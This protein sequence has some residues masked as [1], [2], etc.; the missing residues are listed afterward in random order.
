MTYGNDNTAHRTIKS[1]VLAH[2]HRA[3]GNVDYDALTAEVRQAF[4]DSAWKKTHWAWYKHQILNGRF[5]AMFTDAER[6]ALRDGSP[7]ATKAVTA[8]LLPP[9]SVSKTRGPAAKDPEIKKLGDEVLRQVRFILDVAAND[10]EAKRFRLNRWVFSRLQL[11]EVRVKRP[12][13]KKLWDQGMRHCQAC[14]E[15]FGSLKGVEIHRRDASKG[16]SLENCELLCRECHQ[17][18][19]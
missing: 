5:R 1:L 15:P 6:T 13:K 4:P 10:D 16:Y 17:E 7:A 3:A 19:E 9:T 8:D 18:H 11:D 14:K 12:I 2:V